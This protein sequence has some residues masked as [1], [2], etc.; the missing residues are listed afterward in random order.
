[1]VQKVVSEC[2]RVGY[3]AGTE[4]IAR[5][6]VGVRLAMARVT[7][8][9]NVMHDRV[10]V[11]VFLYTLTYLAMRSICWLRAHLEMPRRPS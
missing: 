11:G 6:C 10:V 9:A 5:G 2:G 8:R 3:V 4:R 7:E 1:V